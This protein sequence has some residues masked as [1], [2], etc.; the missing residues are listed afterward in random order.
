[1]PRY[2]ENFETNTLVFFSSLDHIKGKN[3]Y[4]IMNIGCGEITETIKTVLQFLSTIFIV[5]IEYILYLLNTY[6]ETNA[7]EFSFLIGGI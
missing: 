2:W 4:Q 5:L 6:E 1:M 3:K 7:Q